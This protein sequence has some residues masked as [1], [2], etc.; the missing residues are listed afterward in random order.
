MNRKTLIQFTHLG[1]QIACFIR[2]FAGANYYLNCNSVCSPRCFIH[3][4]RKSS[5]LQQEGYLLKRFRWVDCLGRFEA[6]IDRVR[7]PQ[8]STA[9]NRLGSWNDSAAERCL[10]LESSL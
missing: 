5:E 3:L 10:P 1:K 9:D 7:D 8:W 6:F 4:F 2:L